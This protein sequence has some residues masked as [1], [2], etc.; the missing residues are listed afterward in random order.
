MS[1][2]P[3]SILY[4]PAGVGLSLPD[5]Y[6]PPAGAQGIVAMGSDGI[7]ANFIKT[8]T[9]GNINVVIDPSQATIGVFGRMR[10]SSPMTMFDS[11]QI[12]TNGVSDGFIVQKAIAGATLTYEQAKARTVM[13]LN[14]GATDRAIRQSKVYF[15]YQPGKGQ[16]IYQS[17]NMRG[18]QTGAS[19]KVGYFDDNNGLFL[20]VTPTT[21]SFVRRTK[22]SG[23]VVD[24][25]ITQASWNIDPMNGAG[26]SRITLDTTKVQIL[27][28][29]FEWL[30]AGIARLGFVI[31]GVTYFCHQFAAANISD[32]VYMSTPNLPLRWEIEATAG[33][34]TGSLDAI[35][36]TVVSEGGASNRATRRAASRGSTGI[37]TNA[38]PRP[39]IGIRLKDAA[40]R[41]YVVI[42][43]FTALVTSN[44][45][46]LWSIVMNPT[47]TG[48]T[49]PTWVSASTFMEYDISRTGTY[50]GDGVVIGTGY[51]SDAVDSIMVRLE[52]DALNSVQPFGADLDGVRDE[53][54]L[55]CQNAGSNSNETFL[56][57]M[58]WLEVH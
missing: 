38:T 42:S 39:I 32:V 35:C 37:I 22:T 24:D 5:G 49:G 16:L 36:G 17:F 8:D 58:G 23:V 46:G 26:P 18:L 30:G 44:A 28:V 20:N 10:V 51:F 11:K 12:W 56:G 29:E 9:Y 4:T 31:D 45:Q 40:V 14:G 55:I 48:G 43:D 54:Y 34:S 7:N 25:A 21:V 57:A 1:R 50:N 52:T 2:N 13:A 41:G 27:V 15:N 3:A 33:G 6:A 19:K 53:A 47:F